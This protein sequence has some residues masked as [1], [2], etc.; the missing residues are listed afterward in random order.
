MQ[1]W[2]LASR[3]QEVE[4]ILRPW[5][6]EVLGGSWHAGGLGVVQ[7]LQEHEAGP[8]LWMELALEHGG[9]EEEEEKVVVH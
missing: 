7:V 3:R 5:W 4:T 2:V 9:E 8:Q 1:G 6:K